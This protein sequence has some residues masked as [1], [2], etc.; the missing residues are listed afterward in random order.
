MDYAWF[1][2][3]IE[4]RINRAK[5]WLAT[6]I[7]LCWMIFLGMLT[8][9]VIKMFGDIKTFGFGINDVFRVL[10][11]QSFHSL[12]SAE[13]FPLLAKTVGTLLFAWV[14]AATSIKRLHDRDKSG[15]WMVP[16]FVVPG[17]YNQFESQL[18]DFIAVQLLA[19]VAFIFGLWGFIEMYFLK[20]T[21]GPSRYGAD[22]LKPIDTRGR[23][24]QQDE[25]EFVPHSAGPSAGSHVNRSN[26]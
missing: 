11:P 1:L 6:L 10:D 21:R 4:G 14:Y 5:C 20:G 24:V 12:S 16:F 18:G 9:V 2:F 7:I 8:V 23:W 15:W 22:P 3:R 17:L 25:L 26:D 19:L 13:L